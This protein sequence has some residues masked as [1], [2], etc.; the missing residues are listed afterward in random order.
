MQPSDVNSLDDHMGP[1][2]ATIHKPVETADVRVLTRAGF[3]QALE[4]LDVSGVWQV[5]CAGNSF[6]TG[7]ASFNPWGRGDVY[8]CAA[9]TKSPLELVREGAE[10]RIV[11][12]DIRKWLLRSP[13]TDTLWQDN[14]FQSF[15]GLATGPLVRSLAT[16]VVGKRNV[17]FA[18]PPR[19]N[20]V[21]EE[22][23]LTTELQRPGFMHLQ[24]SVAWVYE[25]Q[26]SAEQ[27]H[28]IYS[29]EFARSVSRDE[30]LGDAFRTAGENILEG[31]RLVYQLSQSELSREA[32]KA[33]GDLRKTISDDMSKVAD[34]TRS[35]T[36]AIAVA[37]ATGIG[38]VA[39]RSTSTGDPRVLSSVAG[40]VALYLIAVTLSGWQYLRLQK[41]LRAQWRQRLYRFIPSEDYAAMVT[42]PAAEAERP[43][44]LMGV[45]GLIIAV[46]LILLAY[47]GWTVTAPKEP[48]PAPAKQQESSYKIH[49]T[50]PPFAQTLRQ[51]TPRNPKDL[52]P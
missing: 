37:V 17:V 44:H 10:K 24:S 2:I 41:R 49:S 6:A 39:T 16:E 32:I 50:P 36:T 29:A 13:I 46:A 11:P 15:A 40:I 51:L 5:A 20:L 23:P 28:A 9:P 18:G 8:V 21:L 4:S 30:S 52:K 7:F 1:Y 3:L 43:Y 22:T 25:D 45:I 27:R 35:L 42:K 38:L 33:Q 14:A 48:Q 34:G 47:L 31:A 12:A 19:L 26:A